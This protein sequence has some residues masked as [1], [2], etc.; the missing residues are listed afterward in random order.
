MPLLRGWGEAVQALHFCDD[1]ITVDIVDTVDAVASIY[2]NF[3]TAFDTVSHKILTDKLLMYGMDEQIVRWI[4]N[5][6]NGQAQS[7]VISG[8]KSSWRPVT[9]GVPQG[10]VLGP[11]LFTIFINDLDDGAEY[12]L[13]KFADDTKL[14]RVADMPEGHAAIQKELNRLEKWADS[15]SCS[16]R[17]CSRRIMFRSSTRRRDNFCTN[18]SLHQDRLGA[19]QLESSLQKRTWSVLVDT[20]LNMSQQCAHVAKKANGILGCIR[21]SIASRSR[22]VI[23]SL[24]SALKRDMDILARVQQ[25]TTK[26]IKGLEHLTYEERLRELGLFSLEEK[27]LRGDLVKLHCCAS[28]TKTE[29]DIRRLAQC[30]TFGTVSH[31]ITRIT[32]NKLMNYR[33]NKCTVRWT[34]NWRNCWA[35]RLVITG[36]SSWRPVTSGVP[37][38]KTL[39]PVLFTI[40]INDLNGRTECILSK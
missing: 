20:K 36:M 10:T 40:F 8:M 24:Y 9:S 28:D 3:S 32:S 21:R 7:L 29:S 19:T 26:M 39:G 14:G 30:R 12:T 11:A 15:R 23:L 33:V 13:S 6:L 22:E 18:N 31:N 4:G 17:S 2:W 37:Q 34:V 25:R 35:Q 27:R 5:W 38:K 16:T 1:L